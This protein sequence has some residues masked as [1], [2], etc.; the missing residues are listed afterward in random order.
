MLFFA[1]SCVSGSNPEQR[2]ADNANAAA[3]R[4]LHALTNSNQFSFIAVGDTHLG[5]DNS[6]IQRILQAATAR[7]NEFFIVLGDIVDRGASQHYAGLKALI[8]TEGWSGRFF[9]ILGN[10]DVMG[11]SWQDFKSN[12]GASYYTFD[13]GNSRFIALDT[14][15]A[16]L[17]DRQ[18]AWFQNELN[19]PR[20]QNTFVLSHYSPIL[21]EINDDPLQYLKFSNPEEGARFMSLCAKRGVKAVL[22]AHYHAYLRGNVGGTDYVVAGGG[23]GRCMHPTNEHFYVEVTVNGGEVGYEKFSVE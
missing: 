8:D 9:P 3:P 12:F 20:P 17:G 19:K 11:S 1:Q 16:T 10:H 4:F 21:P 23:G 2:D 15:D 7:S 13:V 18:W 5:G 22:A 14:A 6:R